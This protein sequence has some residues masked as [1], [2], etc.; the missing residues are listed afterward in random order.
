[1]ISQVIAGYQTASRKSIL[2]VP[3]TNVCQSLDRIEHTR[4]SQWLSFNSSDSEE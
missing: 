4:F 3:S 2:K 1:V